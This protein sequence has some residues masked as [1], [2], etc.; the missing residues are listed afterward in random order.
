MEIN[1]KDIT[2]PVLGGSKRSK[3]KVKRR[4]LN[5]LNL[6]SDNNNERQSNNSIDKVPSETSSPNSEVAFDIHKEVKK[7][8][9]E[10]SNNVHD[11]DYKEN[12][13]LEVNMKYTF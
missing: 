12:K 13:L 4:I 9:I 8:E 6:D 3:R 7:S 2:S 5:N 1:P 10:Q 11:V